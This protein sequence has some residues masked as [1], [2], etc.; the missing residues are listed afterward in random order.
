MRYTLKDIAKYQLGDTIYMLQLVP[1][2]P[3]PE[4]G[5][6]DVWKAECHPK[7]N[8]GPTHRPWACSQSVPRVGEF[9]FVLLMSLLTGRLAVRKFVVEDFKKSRHTGEMLYRHQDEWLPEGNLFESVA[10]A[11]KEISR[12]K[13][14]VQLWGTDGL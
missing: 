12:V 1:K 7:V 11:R 2:K 3:I 5:D 6:D 14:L 13:K 9:D 10:S 8:Y 4:L